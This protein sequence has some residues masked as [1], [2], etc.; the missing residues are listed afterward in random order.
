MPI[1]GGKDP[2][3][4]YPGQGETL[5]AALDDAATQARAAE[6]PDGEILTVVRLR[7]RIS[8]PHVSEYFVDIG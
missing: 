2:T 4:T 8:N 5:E 1:N 3:P 7:V 6:V